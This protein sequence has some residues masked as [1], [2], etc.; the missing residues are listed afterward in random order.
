M[1]F[2]PRRIASLVAAIV[3][4]ALVVAPAAHAQP[5]Q[6]TDDGLVDVI[7]LHRWTLAM[8]EDS[9]RSLR[10]AQS[11]HQSRCQFTLKERFGFAEVSVVIRDQDTMNGGQRLVYKLVEPQDRDLVVYLPSRNGPARAAWAEGRA[12]YG[13]SYDA[14]GDAIQYYSAYLLDAGDRAEEQSRRMAGGARALRYWR[15]LQSHR[16]AG[17]LELALATLRSGSSADRTVAVTVLLNFV[18]DDRALLA[19]VETMR[20]PA[21]VVRTMAGIV[22]QVAQFTLRQQ[23]GRRALDWRPAQE[24][25]AHMLDGTNVDALDHVLRLATV[26][27]IDPRVGRAALRGHSALVLS[28]LRSISPFERQIARDFLRAATGDDQGDDARRWARTLD[29][30]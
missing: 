7:G 14:W 8:L 16:A 10:P 12:V 5:Q 29:R 24:T 27:R 17:D 9:L 23:G 3:V 30:L 4:T 1:S 20:D 19:M 26:T 25:L 13:T 18:N 22:T 6:H 2:R 28:Q 21:F 15:F 11:L